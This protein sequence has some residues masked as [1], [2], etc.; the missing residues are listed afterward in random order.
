MPLS[1]T[2]RLAVAAL[3][4]SLII[5]PPPVR[6]YS[7]LTHEQLID[8][9]WKS[10]IQPLLLRR[11]PTLTPAQLQEAHAYA[12]GGC[13]IQDLG[14]YPFGKAFF[15]DLTHYVR[16]GDFVRALFRDAKNADEVAFAVGALAHYL[17]DTIGH[18]DAVNPSVA[19][20][21][22]KLEAKY[23]P[24]VN[25]AEGEHQ[26]VRT[27]FAFDIN[28]IAKHRIAPERYLNHIGFAVPVALLTRAFYDTYGLDLGHVL[29]NHLPTLR[30]YRYSVRAL[31]PRI[32][33]AETLLYRNRLPPETP[34][35]S[36][37]I[38]TQEVDQLSV[39]NN[40]ALYRR[41]AGIG[42]HLLAGLL[43][44]TPKIGPLSDLALKPPTPETEQKYLDSVVRTNEVFRRLV[45]N[46]TTSDGIDN[47]DLDTGA[48]IR[49]GSYRLA[50]LTYAKLLHT[51]TR[52]PAAPV[53]F[54]IKR[55]L[56]AYFADPNALAA[57][58]GEGKLKAQVQTDLAVLQ[59]ISTHA[60]YPPGAFLPD[61][62]T[63][64]GK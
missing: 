9:A 59:K 26:H 51:I 17:G 41:H 35:A 6:A 56:V 61:D 16:T 21:F 29:G 40:W 20:D 24:S 58:P 30:G 49:P 2:I 5:T 50:D 45:A 62:P 34:S 4:I 13:V 23:G 64:P 48:A 7:V 32:A 15:S 57:I 10:T 3:L 39:D 28:E 27:E 43:F 33:Y 46:A 14:Y 52:D 63:P 19:L 37:T 31:L 1:R 36:L 55:D 47:A 53:P 60:A 54:G 25:Y 42:T 22:P 11:Y 12:Y 44:V 18:P 38:L 8:L